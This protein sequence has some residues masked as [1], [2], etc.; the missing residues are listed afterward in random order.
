[1]TGFKSGASADD[2]F[3]DDSGDDDEPETDSLASETAS[4]ET[5]SRDESEPAETADREQARETD[6]E[7]A[8]E[9]DSTADD[10]P[11]ADSEPTTDSR[12]LPWIYERNSITDGRKKTVQ[13]H[14]QKSSLDR[15]RDAR[16]DVEEVL[17]ESVKKADLREAALVVGLERIDEVADQ[18]REWG[19]DFE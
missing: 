19:Y 11:S 14:L 13:L 9:S 17:G 10:E 2:P 7:T 16:L 18:L 5:A 12:G 8:T 4:T 6:S 15:E 1:M 3:S